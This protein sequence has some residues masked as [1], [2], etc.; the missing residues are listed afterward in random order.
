MIA[1]LIA[2][3]LGLG[4]VTLFIISLIVFF[5][6]QLLPGDVAQAILGRTAPPEAV[7]AL[8][9]RLGL[10]LPAHVRYLQWAGGLFQGDFGDS[11]ANR[12]PVL[13]LLS[14]RI[15][16][17]FFLAAVSACIAVPLGL[18]LGLAS[19][20]YR[21]RPFDH[22][23]SL[24][25]LLAISVPEFLTAYILVAIFAV[26]LGWLPAVSMVQPSQGILD[27]FILISLPAATLAL[28]VIAYILRMTR[29]AIG[30]VLSSPYIEMAKLKGVSPYR[31]VVR[32]ALPNALSPI[33]NVVLMN[34]AYLVVGVVVVEVIF[35]YPGLGQ[36]LVDSV[37]KR[38]IPVVQ[39]CGVLFATAYILLNL[40]ADVLSILANPRLRRP[41]GGV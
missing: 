40:L 37:S 19:A 17:T 28:G 3:R 41:R 35:V 29:A 21:S 12:R 36:L 2:K 14:E 6:V 38:D 24:A 30:N 32:H 8:R 7:A 16:N 33:I 5:S 22:A 10:D 1:L 11:L 34:L 18:I 31:L 25:A 39:A 13:D 9:T 26:E 4:L 15:G 23:T 20:I 27:R